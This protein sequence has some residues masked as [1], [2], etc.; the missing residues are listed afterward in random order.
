[1]TSNRRQWMFA[2]LWNVLTRR[3]ARLWFTSL[4]LSDA[5]GARDRV[6]LVFESWALFLAFILYVAAVLGIFLTVNAKGRNNDQL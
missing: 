6:A 1:M 2:E 3:E 4:A 5:A